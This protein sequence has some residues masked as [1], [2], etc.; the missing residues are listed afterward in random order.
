MTRRAPNLLVWRCRRTT[1]DGKREGLRGGFTLVELLVVMGVIG[2]M[3]AVLLPAVQ[4]AREAARR[5]E[6]ANHL[7]Q[8]SLG[9]HNYHAVYNSFPAGF[10]KDWQ[11]EAVHWSEEGRNGCWAWSAM[12]LPFV[13]QQTLHD[14]LD[15]GKVPAHVAVAD[16][17]RRS[18]MQKRISL[19]RCPSDTAPELNTDQQVP[20]GAAGDPNCTSGCVPIATSN[21]VGSN[22]SWDLNRTSW[23]GFMGRAQGNPVQVT[24]MAQ[25]TDGT[26]NT[27]ALGERA[28]QL[29]GRPLQAAVALM[30]NGDSEAHSDQGSVYAVG[31][32]RY[33]LNCTDSDACARG[34]SSRHPGGSQ[35]ALV[36]GSVR[37]VNEH[38]D[39]NTSDATI[40]S[41]Y[42]RLISINDGQSVGEY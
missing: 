26:S 22:H 35:F 33:R 2:S 9:L 41:T 37:F 5:A 25:I 18:A 23:N 34:F 19:F 17:A 3:V 38:I 13:E 21:Y 36:D 24:T 40:D 6:C 27:F 12:L 11:Q 39:H 20:Y 42:E 8:L 16:P 7:K 1:R 14:V 29:N 10:L 30:T 4:A 28:W 31:C 15:V 32:G